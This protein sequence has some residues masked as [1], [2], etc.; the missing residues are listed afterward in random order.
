MNII[1]VDNVNV[2]T[3]PASKIKCEVPSPITDDS[4]SG[5]TNC[6]LND[7]SLRPSG[8]DDGNPDDEDNDDVKTNADYNDR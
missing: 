4:S 1:D 6:G 8:R 7:L 5:Q 2:H 3:T